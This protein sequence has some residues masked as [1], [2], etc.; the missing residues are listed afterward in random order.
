MTSSQRSTDPWMVRRLS[1]GFT[2]PTR[3]WQD[4]LFSPL[5][6]LPLSFS[7]AHA[8]TRSLIFATTWATMMTHVY[9]IRQDHK[10][11]F[12]PS[13]LWLF[14]FTNVSDLSRDCRIERSSGYDLKNRMRA[15]LYHGLEGRVFIYLGKTFSG[16]CEDHLD[17]ALWNKA[18]LY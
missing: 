13:F 18:R 2:L 9:E 15:F 11:Y 4:L 7:H 8:L 5:S 10:R 17:Y 14:S 1:M 3:T 6:P 12:V 16:T